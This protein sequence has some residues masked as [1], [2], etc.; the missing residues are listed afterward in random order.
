[1]RDKLIKELVGLSSTTFDSKPVM[2][3]IALLQPP[4]TAEIEAAREWLVER[5]LPFPDVYRTL[6]RALDALAREPGLEEQLRDAAYAIHRLEAAR[7]QLDGEKESIIDNIE[8]QYADL[9]TAA[10]EV[11]EEHQHLEGAAGYATMGSSEIRALRAA[12]INLH[13]KRKKSDKE[14]LDEFYEYLRR[15]PSSYSADAVSN[16]MDSRKAPTEK[17]P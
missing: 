2:E 16:F 11:L 5:R 1:M 7:R 9:L 15:N 4:T 17:K 8:A 13:P 12:V 14:L 6:D 10:K 3:A